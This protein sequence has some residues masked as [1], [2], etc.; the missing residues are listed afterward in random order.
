MCASTS[1]KSISSPMLLSQCVPQL[2]WNLFHYLSYS[3]NVCLNFPEIYFITCH[4]HNGCINFP[5]IYFITY[6]TLT[7]CAPTSLKSILPMLI[8][9]WVPQLPWNL[10]HYLCYSDNGCLNFHEIYII[11]YVTLMT[12]GTSTSLKSISL[13]MLLWQ[14]VPQLPWNLYHY[15]CNSDN[16]CLNFPEI[17]IIIYVTLTMGAST[18]LKSISLFMLISQSVP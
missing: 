8:W 6:V 9:Q 1:L 12:M 7:M 17:Y 14:W 11:T 18:S 13:P 2:P 4:S 15:L 5:Q 16:G 3:H 10:Y